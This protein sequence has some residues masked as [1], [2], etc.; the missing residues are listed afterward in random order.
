MLPSIPFPVEGH[1]EDDRSVNERSFGLNNGRADDETSVSDVE[2]VRS[3]S[4]H[5][6]EDPDADRSV[7]P[8]LHLGAVCDD[9]ME[10]QQRKMTR[11]CCAGVRYHDPTANK[12]A[13]MIC[14]MRKNS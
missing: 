7:G 6:V 4:H 8:R 13:P 9:E 2:E 1:V 3:Q 5:A 11:E 12:T 10:D 14:V